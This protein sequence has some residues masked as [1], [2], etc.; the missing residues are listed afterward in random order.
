MTPTISLGPFDSPSLEIMPWDIHPI[1]T[2]MAGRF[3]SM[4]T[5]VRDSIWSFLQLDTLFLEDETEEFFSALEGVCR[6]IVNGDVSQYSIIDVKNSE[7]S[8]DLKRNANDGVITPGVK[9]AAQR[10]LDFLAANPEW[11]PMR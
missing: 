8:S 9:A 10:F 2:T 4:S 5:E 1:I 11:W 6:G 3:P 7:F